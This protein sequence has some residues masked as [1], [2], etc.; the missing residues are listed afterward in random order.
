MKKLNF[1]E[2][3]FKVNRDAKG[4]QIFDIVRKKFVLLTPEEW[5]RQHA[6]HFLHLERGFPIGLMAVEKEIKV[7][8]MK[9]RFDLVC[10]NTTG[11]PEMICE[12]KRPTVPIDESTFKQ[13]ANYNLILKAPLVYVT[14]GL[15]HF[16][17]EINFSDKTHNFL[18][19]IPDFK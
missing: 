7:N 9:K 18:L 19:E 4:T 17:A 15:S 6:I 12:F 3:E 2:Y 11:L 1:P 16:V 14:N 5:V 13:V 8:N 10:Y